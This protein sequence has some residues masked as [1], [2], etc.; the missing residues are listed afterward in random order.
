MLSKFTCTDRQKFSDG[1]RRMPLVRSNTGRSQ[2]RSPL[3]TLSTS[4][5]F[6][7]PSHYAAAA[8]I[9]YDDNKHI[10]TYNK[11]DSKDH[12]GRTFMPAYPYEAD[13][14]SE[15][16]F[17]FK[18]NPS[19]EDKPP[20]F[21]SRSNRRSRRE[22]LLNDL[23]Q[24]E[25]NLLPSL[26]DT[27]DRM[28]KS[29]A[30][31]ESCS[32]SHLSIPRPSGASRSSRSLSPAHASREH[33]MP[34]STTPELSS[35]GRSSPVDILNSQTNLPVKLP[36]RSTLRPPAAKIHSQPSDNSPP[37]SIRSIL[38]KIPKRGA[39]PSPN[40][41]GGGSRRS[42][43]SNG[44]KPALPPSRSRS[45]TDPG[46]VPTVVSF[47]DQYPPRN[48]GHG[49]SLPAPR[50][51]GIP[52]LQARRTG[53]GTY[54][55]TDES[56]GDSRYEPRGRGRNHSVVS[57]GDV[58]SGSESEAERRRGTNRSGGKLVGLGIGVGSEKKKSNGGLHQ[59][60]A[61]YRSE[62]PSRSARLTTGDRTPARPRSFTP[63]GPLEHDQRRE[64]LLDI[65]SRLNLDNNA[66]GMD[67]DHNG[68]PICVSPDIAD[69]TQ[70][71]PQQEP[72]SENNSDYEQEYQEVEDA[73]SYPRKDRSRSA[74]HTPK[75]TF[76][77]SPNLSDQHSSQPRTT[78]QNK[79]HLGPP[80]TPNHK[81]QSKSPR[82]SSRSPV[83]PQID[84][85][86]IP[87]ALRRHSVYHHAA[88]PNAPTATNN[89]SRDDKRMSG[90]RS[91]NASA[92][93][94]QQGSNQ[95]R[96]DRAPNVNANADTEVEARPYT[97]AARERKAY[98]IP[99]SDSDSIGQYQGDE[100]P[101]LPHAESDL[102]SV[103]SMYWGDDSESELSPAAETLFRKL[104]RGRG[105]RRGHQPSTEKTFR[106][107]V[108]SRASSPSPPVRTTEAHWQAR[109]TSPQHKDRPCSRLASPHPVPAGP[110]NDYIA[111]DTELRRQD[112]I[113]E[114][115][116][117]EEAFVK[118][119]QVFVQ[120]FILPLRVQDTKE[121]IAGVPT[122][123]ARLFDWLEDIVVLHTQILASLETT[124]D[125]QYPTVERFAE[126]IRTFI[127]RL[128]VYQPYLVNLEAVIMLVEQL[129]G[130]E[131]SDFGEFV[132]L[133][134]AASDCVGWNFQ[135]FLIEPV[136][137]L[138]KFPQLFSKLLEMTPK[139]HRDY[140]PTLA[141]VRSA[142]M[143][144]RVMTEVKIREDEYDMIQEFAAHI[145]G[146]S[147]S[148]QIATRERRLLH[149]GVLHLV[150]VEAN[151]L[152]VAAGTS[153]LF[154]YFPPDANTT[155]ANR[156]GKL[157]TA[158]HQWETTGRG[159][160]G[161][162]SSS[163]IGV[164]LSSLKASSSA[165]SSIFFSSFKL[166]IP[167]GRLKPSMTKR[168]ASPSPAPRRNTANLSSPAS[169]GTLVQ[170]F[171]FTD[172][173]LL[174][175]QDPTSDS[176]D[177]WTLLNHIG[178]TRILS[179][180][181]QEDPHGHDSDAGP[182]S[183]VTITL[184]V[185][186]VDA[187]K[188]NN[189]PNHD[190]DG[191]SVFLLHL[192]LPPPRTDDNTEDD[193]ITSA[194]E[195][196]TALRRCQQFML[197]SLATPTKNHDPQLDVAYDK[198]QAVFSLLAS[199]LPL[200]KSPSAQIADIQ[201]GASDEA[202]MMQERE[203]R[204]WWSLRF[205]QVFRELQRQDLMTAAMER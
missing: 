195:W 174:A 201:C 59:T 85:D 57:R 197:C 110:S 113:T 62:I 130:D 178:T 187:Q 48:A 175:T 105:D 33:P 143:F 135:S 8:G 189:T 63:D 9:T 74:S 3:P 151:D 123:V 86:A 156:T 136:N 184:E 16:S 141:L 60:A 167:Q 152:S 191:S 73:L 147:S 82:E 84:T 149:Q 114:I 159:R 52:R 79:R 76:L 50:P 117:T 177:G 144:I 90:R 139:N 106:S 18:S 95:Q 145:Q 172:L 49:D 180:Q 14:A 155:A 66:G 61:P 5:Q 93:K 204:G 71:R 111:V 134:E 116:H 158:I 89:N 22:S 30:Q 142:E 99:P 88:S 107:S 109:S 70:A 154:R 112:L 23:P 183:P 171:V 119:L 196:Q 104:G 160:S 164:S 47:A 190:L 19:N 20:P 68:P 65:V 125:A 170:V 194:R 146:L 37:G 56:D 165:A 81:A 36:P 122:E 103:G 121:W 202:P 34:K 4:R 188:L 87:A 83:V 131:E 181:P 41:D 124:R 150:D 173:L 203:E 140:L 97:A 199:G 200:P 137:V 67:S 2:T 129:I 118:R 92:T 45:R 193:A 132:H 44:S 7:P 53:M 43:I 42:T 27:I 35:R 64:A 72:E 91:L 161:S 24:L 54:W 98:G 80:P 29:P 198:H 46:A 186:S 1:E 192:E 21:P 120:L 28:T 127:P 169:C 101:Y 32:A 96:H 26:R 38:K 69:Q 115:H 153:R 58:Q 179:V 25:A 6:L 13:S 55:S 78:P 163:S 31:T 168:P 205:Q 100:D 138:A 40:P 182:D 166:A 176:G 126:S 39:T 51:S 77:L 102:S 12:Y 17:E 10:T 185:L 148:T 94:V 162:T 157:A 15:S 108:L 128:E 75:P 11:G 133:Q